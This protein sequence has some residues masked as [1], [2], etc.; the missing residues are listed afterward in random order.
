MI[1]VSYFISRIF[2]TKNITKNATSM[3]DH[4]AHEYAEN[5]CSSD[6]G[7]SKKSGEVRPTNNS[8]EERRE[9][10]QHEVQS[11]SSSEVGSVI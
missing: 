1:T 9:V 7:A 2:P 10:E 3:Y 8:V 5:Q 4:E 6:R 11:A